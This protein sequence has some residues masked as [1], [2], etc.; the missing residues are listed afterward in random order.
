MLC[1]EGANSLHVACSEG[2]PPGPRVY[3]PLV[4]IVPS[5]EFG[6]LGCKEITPVTICDRQVGKYVCS[7]WPGKAA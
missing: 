6:S 4:P 7:S 1:G 2:K 5:L 3:G